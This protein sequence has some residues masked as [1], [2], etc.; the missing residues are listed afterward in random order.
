MADTPP[1][2]RAGYIT[3]RDLEHHR[4]EEA[5]LR[6]DLER[7][8]TARF[9]GNENRLNT[10]ESIFDQQRGARALAYILVGSNVLM[11]VS[12]LLGLLSRH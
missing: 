4:A 5:R 10:M 8:M 12:V 11:A 6:E 3:W 2:W 9:D 7:R 1:D